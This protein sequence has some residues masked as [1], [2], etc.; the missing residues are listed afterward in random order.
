M[1]EGKSGKVLG[2]TIAVLAVAMVIYHLVS[3]QYLFQS[4]LEHKNTHL[5][6]AL[7]LVFLT[8]LK[9]SRRLWLLTLLLVLLS[10]ASTAYVQIFQ[11]DLQERVGFPTSPDMIIGFLLVIL[12][13][14]ATRRSFGLVVPLICTLAV[15]YAFLGQYLPGPL[16]APSYPVGGVISRLSIGLDG[17]YGVV[18]GISAY[19][20]F[21]FIV[22]GAMLQVTGATRFFNEVGR[23][24]GSRVK[25]G[26]A[27]AAVTTSA[28]VG[29]VTGS[30]AAN[31]TITGAFTIPLMKRV[32]YSPEQA[33]AIE[34]T[35]STGGQIMPPVMGAAAFVMAAFT[36]IPYVKI[37]AVAAIPA[38]LYFFTAGLY[39]QLQAM[40]MNLSPVAERA[41]LKELF[42]FAPLFIVPL[43]TLIFL[44]ARGNTAAYSIF[45][46]L[47]SIVILSL[48]RKESRPSMRSWLQGCINAAT[49]GA[50]IGAISAAIGLVIVTLSMTGLGVKL[51]GLVETWSGGHLLVALIITMVA[52]IILGA[53]MPTT[54]VYVLV[55]IV[56][57]PALM[58]MGLGLLQAHFFV[59][60]FACLNFVTPPVAIG[61]LIASKLAGAD[62]LKTAVESV[63]VALGG[64]A[65]PFLIIASPV[66]V[67]Q[68]KDP[69]S[70]AMGL[71]ASLLG[72]A[73]LQIAVS[74]Y[75]LTALKVGERALFAGIAGALFASLPTQNYVF[76]ASGLILFVVLTLWQWR[77]RSS[78]EYSAAYRVR[79]RS[80][81]GS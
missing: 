10:L 14:E 12:A 71:V 50:Q 81:Q 26:P 64:F 3:T 7:T 68:A 31:I 36:G 22:F 42:L 33:A 66:L 65:V 51:P 75:Y 17:I 9:G 32:G 30:V 49:A 6:L 47:I 73:V 53:G 44:L 63:K 19:Y 28:L 29:S 1:S 2:V 74:N 61:S 62:Y 59:F 41:N 56:T 46:A 37:I 21:M 40:K 23:L 20:I 39:V 13:I 79:Q 48:L 72:L 15:A 55:A 25:S 78:L 43:L 69:I 16:H 77:K 67:L 35:A 45:W 4:T 76:F 60:Y 27:M 24:A 11:D 38:I 34:A 52:S 5:A 57:A 8:S 58:K 54:A 70:G 18:L 80:D